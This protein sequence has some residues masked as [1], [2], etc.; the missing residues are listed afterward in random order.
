MSN[1][2]LDLTVAVTV[3]MLF[4]LKIGFIQFTSGFVTTC[5][6]LGVDLKLCSLPY[7]VLNSNLSVCEV[8]IDFNVSPLSPI[9]TLLTWLYCGF[10]GVFVA[11]VFNI[12]CKKVWHLTFIWWCQWYIFEMEIEAL[13]PS[14]VVGV[15]HQFKERLSC[16]YRFD[17]GLI[18]LPWYLLVRQ[19]RHLCYFRTYSRC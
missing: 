13:S 9:R 11:L 1:I 15:L 3:G 19:I 12:Y 8:S 16:T 14:G 10:S 6:L 2:R 5:Q 18:L 17:I 7:S 4:A